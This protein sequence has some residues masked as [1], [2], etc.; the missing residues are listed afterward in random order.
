MSSALLSWVQTAGGDTGR[1]KEDMQEKQ[2]TLGE[3]GETLTST[4]VNKGSGKAAANF[5]LIHNR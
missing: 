3:N 4:F 5:L 1:K 2:N